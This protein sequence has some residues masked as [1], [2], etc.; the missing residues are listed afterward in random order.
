MSDVI[1]YKDIVAMR[2][3][4]ENQEVLN[5]ED[6][7]TLIPNRILFEAC[8]HEEWQD[9]RIAELEAQLRDI[10]LMATHLITAI[11]RGGDG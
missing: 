11:K 7:V 10:T 1:T 5:I 2:E 8:N 4:L 9:R 3:A 6:A